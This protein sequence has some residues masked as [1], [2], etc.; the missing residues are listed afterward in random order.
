MRIFF[1]GLLVCSMPVKQGLHA[2]Y[3]FYNNK[4]YENKLLAELGTGIGIMNALT[5][6]GGKQG[7]G[8]KFIKDLSWRNSKPCFGIYILLMYKSVIGLRIEGDF[9]QVTAYDSILKDV[10]ASTFGRY[11]RNL[12]FK[13]RIADLQLGIEVHPLFFKYYTDKEPPRLSPYILVGAGY[14]SF[15]PQAKLNGQW[16]SL[17]PL[18]T[19]GQGFDEYPDRKPYR[20]S[21]FN[22]AIGHGI[23]YEINSLLNARM[24]INYRFLFTDY[25]DDVSRDYIDAGLF[26]DYLPSRLAGLARQLYSRKGELDP[27]TI[28]MPGD[29]RGNPKNND[30]F[31]TIQL[32]LGITPGRQRR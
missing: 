4:Y 26:K 24:E 19:E 14:F 8:K 27:G 22:I 32:K 25:L 30:A 17:Q 20:L 29:Q 16:Y 31:F 12:S 9:G 6:L 2:Q 1:T 21:Q 7:T 13:S 28:T 11:E 5:D 15:D 23:R 3:Y 18:R 10:R